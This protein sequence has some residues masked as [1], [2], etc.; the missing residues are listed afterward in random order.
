[1]LGRRISPRHAVLAAL[2]SIVVAGGLA[3]LFGPQGGPAS[4]AE[5]AQAAPHRLKF[6]PPQDAPAVEWQA[7]IAT[8][9]TARNVVALQALIESRPGR[10]P[11][12]RA[13]LHAE[14]TGALAQLGPD[15]RLA[16]HDLL[17]SKHRD[18]RLAAMNAFSQGFPAERDGMI[19]AALGDEDPVVRAK[20]QALKAAIR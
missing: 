17:E 5:P 20:A 1:M 4:P 11:S 13:R 9:R 12:E 14:A 15:A 3:W 18:V 2:S 8:Q 10:D 16:F 19:A 7:T 6:L